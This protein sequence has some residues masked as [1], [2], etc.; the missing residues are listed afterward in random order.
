MSRENIKDLHRS[1]LLSS[2]SKIRSKGI[3]KPSASSHLRRNPLF[4]PEKE[5]II[6]IRRTT[7]L[8]LE[9]DFIVETS[10]KERLFTPTDVKEKERVVL[11]PIPR[12]TPLFT[13]RV[14]FEKEIKE[15]P[16]STRSLFT[17]SPTEEQVEIK[18]ISKPSIFTVPPIEEEIEIETEIPE[19]GFVI[20]KTKEE[21]PSGMTEVQKELIDMGYVPISKIVINKEG[22]MEAKYIKVLNKYCQPV[23]I[24]LD[25]E[26]VLSVEK[27]TVSHIEM[28]TAMETPYDIRM[29][30]LECAG[31]DVC[32]VAFECEGGVCTLMKE[33][34]FITAPRLITF[35]KS[36]REE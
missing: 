34:G 4:A 28:K 21:I 10:K 36:E 6:V 15:K 31:K 1:G 23:Y 33:E 29:E 25:T 17:V 16:S 11:P 12:R 20:H 19:E 18:E 8:S 30:A 26:G 27:G 24:E 14:T 35:I 9:E 13:E 22:D 3:G 5:K 2:R 32:G 7:P